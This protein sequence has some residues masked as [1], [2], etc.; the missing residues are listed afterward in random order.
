MLFPKNF[1]NGAFK[2]WLFRY[3]NFNNCDFLPGL[4]QWEFLNG[5]HLIYRRHIHRERAY[6]HQQGRTD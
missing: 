4:V 1:E 6:G 3:W 2:K 5:R